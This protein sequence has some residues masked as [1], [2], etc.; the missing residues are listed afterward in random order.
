[1]KNNEPKRLLSKN[2]KSSEGQGS[3]G[4]DDSS[5]ENNG[6]ISSNPKYESATL[7]LSLVHDGDRTRS[8]HNKNAVRFAKKPS[9]LAAAM[10]D[11]S[12]SSDSE[13]S[14][15]N[16]IS[17]RNKK[18]TNHNN[19]K[20][21]KQSSI[22]SKKPTI[23]RATFAKV[24]NRVSK[25]GT[26]ASTTPENT[27]SSTAASK[28]NKAS[29]P[30][31]I[32]SPSQLQ[33]YRII[34][35]QN[36]KG[37]YRERL[38]P[39]RKLS[40]GEVFEYKRKHGGGD[41]DNNNQGTTFIEYLTLSTEKNNKKRYLCVDNNLLIPFGYRSRDDISFTFND[42]YLQ[43]YMQEQRNICS[44]SQLEAQKLFIER[45][46]HHAIQLEEELK[47]D[48]KKDL[49]DY[50]A[51]CSVERGDSRVQFDV[52]EESESDNDRS[53]D[54]ELDIPYTQAIS[55]D[56]DNFEPIDENEKSNEPMRV[57]DVIQ[58][59]S[60]IF[61][62]GDPR[63]LRET[64]VLA[65]DPKKDNPLVLD[66]AEYVPNDTNVKRIKVISGGEL[67]D[68][69]GIF[70]PIFRF[71]LV[72]AGRATMADAVRMQSS[73]FGGIM[74]NNMKKLKSKAEA[75]GFAPMDLMVSMKGVNDSSQS[76]SSGGSVHKPK[77]SRKVQR[78]QSSSSSS[79]S[80]DEESSD[81]E[82]PVEESKPLA[83]DRREVGKVE[84]DRFDTPKLKENKEN[85][86]S[87]S[88]RDRKLSL[89]S[90]SSKASLG[91]SLASSDDDDSSIE[92]VPLNLGEN[93]RNMTQTCQQNKHGDV[94]KKAKTSGVLDLSISSDDS[95]HLSPRKATKKS[96]G[97]TSAKQTRL[98][99]YLS[100]DNS[101]SS[102]SSMEVIKPK[103]S[104]NTT[105]DNSSC[106][107]A[108]GSSKQ[109]TELRKR[110]PDSKKLS[111]S[112]SS[113]ASKA[114]LSE[115]SAESTAK[116][117][118][119]PTTNRVKD[120]HSSASSTTASTT[121][122]RK[123]ETDSEA[124]KDLGWTQTSGGWVKSDENTGFSLS[125]GRFKK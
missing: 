65:I 53:D 93:H 44:P 26:R 88:C 111:S 55:L 83:S 97:A 57:G 37:T 122:Q 104:K 114:S 106:S 16:I 119:T 60:P 72:R 7:S 75:E 29:I 43:R 40:R 82:S 103:K 96:T 117:K 61:V 17:N 112:Y 13:G 59:Y 125:I 56:P 3:N 95:V 85:A 48:A 1:M 100:S 102:E 71:K 84:A 39:C 118:R 23:A 14:H 12:S 66:N 6:W 34:L 63:G 4:E 20:S 35:G 120:V 89:G 109:G 68:H 121:K 70:R 91:T 32:T 8:S 99:E 15:M 62:A 105:F 50:Y 107:T 38:Q 27:P 31:G 51:D 90:L 42:D 79:E 101:E 77:A 25:A 64:T 69:P 86:S 115:N 92:S 49:E 74:R 78:Q 98:K 52:D 33:W 21:T 113:S 18:K 58:Y 67:V 45:V 28:A 94:I 9:T 2:R 124:T 87:A 5:I 36:K 11:G 19:G 10:D 80:S 30:E 110:T 41:F 47:E 54:E 116:R 73:R 22:K 108:T 24:A 123:K 76:S 81:D 46:F